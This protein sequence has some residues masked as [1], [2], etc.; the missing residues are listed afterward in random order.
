M[1][2]RKSKYIYVKKRDG[3]CGVGTYRRTVVSL[4]FL[5]VKIECYFSLYLVDALSMILIPL[6]LAETFLPVMS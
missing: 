1:L 3:P 2:K 4:F 5:L 6:V